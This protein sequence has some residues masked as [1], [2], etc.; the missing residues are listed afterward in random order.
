MVAVVFTSQ[1]LE[2]INS[3][4]GV[5]FYDNEEIKEMM[6]AAKL[7]VAKKKSL[8]ARII[9]GLA[10]LSPAQIR[11]TNLCTLP[12][13]LIADKLNLSP[14]T[15]KRHLNDSKKALGAKNIAELV[16]ILNQ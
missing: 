5:I 1:G 14:Y 4:E 13:K 11:V 15:V 10:K 9:K 3:A 8:N 12:A 6:R 2:V 16:K 7:T